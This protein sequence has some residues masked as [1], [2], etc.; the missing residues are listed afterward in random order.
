MNKLVP[1]LLLTAILM[2][3]GCASKQTS[4]KANSTLNHTGKQNTA[5]TGPQNLNTYR[6]KLNTSKS[7][8]NKASI[9]QARLETF[10]ISYT[11]IRPEN[12]D[13]GNYIQLNASKDIRD[14]L[15]SVL[16]NKKVKAWFRLKLGSGNNLSLRKNHSTSISGNSVFIS[17][18]E[19]LPGK[20]VQI[21][22]TYVRLVNVS[23]KYVELGLKAYSSDDVISV[24]RNQLRLVRTDSGYRFSFP[25]TISDSA[26]R[27][28]KRIAQNYVTGSETGK[29][30]R[31]L[32]QTTGEKAHIY[33]RYAGHLKDN[34]SISSAFK[35]DTV[36]R[37]NIQGRNRTVGNT[38]SE[39]QDII[40]HLEADQL[41]GEGWIVSEKN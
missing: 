19:I 17:G 3:S 18:K 23:G 22:G 6:I 38:R 10:N 8:R 20:T 28:I 27:K 34:L 21:D 15:E 31:Y 1:A 7:P 25:V 41:P 5:E 37:I 30:G 33:L 29:S 36:S 13:K 26:A 39:A 32:Y 4:N 24:Y 35:Y 2:T 40:R 11:T 9:L 12:T 14:R 16:K